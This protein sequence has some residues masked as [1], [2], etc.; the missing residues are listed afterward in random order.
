[1]KRIILILA[2]L[3]VLLCGCGKKEKDVNLL[4]LS[5]INEQDEAR[6]REHI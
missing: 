3:L 4:V 6:M 2:A 1:M 5:W